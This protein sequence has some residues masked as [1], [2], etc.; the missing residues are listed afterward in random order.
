M[1][2][3]RK[4][5]IAFEI[6]RIVVAMAIAYLLAML[7]LFLISDQPLEAIKSFAFGPLSTKRRFSSVIELMIPFMLTGTSMC[8]MYSANRFNLASEGIFLFA[9][10]VITLCSFYLDLPKGLFAGVLI[11]IGAVV[12]GLLAFVV[13]FAREKFHANEVVISIMLNYSLLYFSNYIL[14]NFMLDTSVTYSASYPINENAKLTR[15]LSGTR[16]HSG[17]FVAIAAVIIGYIILYKT[18]LGMKIRSCG[19]NEN[20]AKTVGINAVACC[21]I[22]QV[23]GGAFAGVGGTV[24]ILGLFDRFQWDSLTQYGFDGLLVSV[25]AKRNPI[26]V[27][28]GSFLLAYL[29]IGADIVNYSTDVPAEFVSILQAIIILLVAAQ[30]FLGATKRKTIYKAAQKEMLEEKGEPQE[31]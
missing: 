17:I 24:Q 31:C 2:K 12:G 7:V 15:L 28:I 11:L 16:L 10:C 13:A 5:E 6:L 8:M 29:R 26:L 4:I 1:K 25:L 30:E 23:L 18:P 21:I 19:N 27:P 20:F 9:G 3:T 14:R 22:A